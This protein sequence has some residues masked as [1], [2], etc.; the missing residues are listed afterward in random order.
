MHVPFVQLQGDDEFVRARA[1]MVLACALVV[2]RDAT[3]M[4]VDTRWRKVLELF[5]YRT[6]I[7]VLL[8]GKGDFEPFF[9]D[10]DLWSDLEKLLAEISGVRDGAKAKGSND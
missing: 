10:R 8:K 3:N 5:N 2:L 7:D 4:V 1:Y 9:E 6:V